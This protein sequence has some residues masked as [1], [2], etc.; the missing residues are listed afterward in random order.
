MMK[1]V[2][3]CLYVFADKN[4]LLKNNWKLPMNSRLEML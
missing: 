1:T 3:F 4:T 2:Y